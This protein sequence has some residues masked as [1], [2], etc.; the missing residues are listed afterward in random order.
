MFVQIMLVSKP[1]GMSFLLY[2][3]I[4]GASTGFRRVASGEAMPHSLR[5]SQQRGFRSHST[6]IQLS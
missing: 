6:R 4:Q 1:R 3:R 5:R 2:A